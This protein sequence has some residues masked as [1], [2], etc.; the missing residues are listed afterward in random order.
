MST[1]NPMEQER[2]LDLL[3]DRAVGELSPADAA[4]LAE[5]L[6]RA[7]DEAGFEQLVGGLLL[8]ADDPGEGDMPG[9]LRAGLQGKGERMV[10]PA[11]AGRIGPGSAPAGAG[12]AQGGWVGWVAAAAAIV[13]A[14]IGWL[15]PPA[16]PMRPSLPTP[17]QRLMAL[18]AEPDTQIIPF[19]G[20]GELAATGRAGEIVWN[21]RL[22]EGFLRLSA[23]PDNN[24][25][26]AQYQLWIF[27]KTRE[28]YAVDGGVFNVARPGAGEVVV[29]FEPK[30]GVGDAAAFAVTKERPGGV[31]VT[32]QSGLVLL[33]PVPPGEG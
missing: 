19:E 24:P 12:P 5:L 29:P 32:D 31:V 21:K 33:A 4:E 11:T 18:E 30:L 17:A 22:Q 10:G 1:L 26:E 15:R 25:T 14:A 9:T 6:S 8:A 3:A 23:L 27:D 13:L 28:T 16:S 7:P 2:L 20:Q